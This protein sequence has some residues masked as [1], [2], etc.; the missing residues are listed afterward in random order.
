VLLQWLNFQEY[1]LSLEGCKISKCGRDA[2]T[3]KVKH[4]EIQLLPRLQAAA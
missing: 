4:G 3:E 1:A 2:R